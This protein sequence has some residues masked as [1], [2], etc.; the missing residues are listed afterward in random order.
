[1][2]QLRLYILVVMNPRERDFGVTIWVSTSRSGHENEDR[3][4]MNYFKK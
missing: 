3:Q 1:M 4:P 2:A